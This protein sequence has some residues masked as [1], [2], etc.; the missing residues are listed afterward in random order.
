MKTYILIIT[1]VFLFFSSCQTKTKKENLELKERITVL[2]QENEAY[3]KKEIKLNS[4]I[5][6]YR[7]FLKE[8][9]NNLKEIDISSS[10][11]GKL[12][13]EINKDANIQSEIKSRLKAVDELIRNSKLKIFALDAQLST[14]RKTSKEKSEEILILEAEL[15]EAI[16]DL[17]KR[18][19]EYLELNHK[20][21]EQVALTKDLNAILNRAYYFI[22]Y[23][24]ELKDKGIVENEGGFIGLGK[25]KVVNANAPDSLFTQIRKDEMDSLLFSAKKIE[26]VTP[27]PENSY[28]IK[29]KNYQHALV[30]TDREKFWG[31]GNYLI[32]Q[33]Y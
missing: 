18:E 33:K 5:K 13:S 8:I 17:L 21:D 6:D 30:I 25:V 32:I 28:I 16:L 24:K 9:N 23:S 22:G 4:S 3:R 12:D 14:L 27:H 15:G 20:L 29:S 2:E 26:L 7:K 1:S 19:N 11:I 10:I 31:A